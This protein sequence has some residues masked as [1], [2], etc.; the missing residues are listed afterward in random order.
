MS[1]DACYKITESFI[2]APGVSASATVGGSY[3]PISAELSVMFLTTAPE[4]LDW[5]PGPVLWNLTRIGYS[6]RIS[7]VKVISTCYF[8][9]H[10]VGNDCTPDDVGLIIHGLLRDT[11][12]QAREG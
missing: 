1:V 4:S 5:N 7:R 3:G 10:D 8:Y 12:R 9:V 6:K 2:S 11:P